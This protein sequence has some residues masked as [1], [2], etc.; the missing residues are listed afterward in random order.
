MYC[1]ISHDYCD[2]LW[3]QNIDSSVCLDRYML[4]GIL[5]ERMNKTTYKRVDDE[6]GMKNGKESVHLINSESM[7]K[8][9][10]RRI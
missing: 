4:G 8:S 7:L 9:I 3:T 2:Q 6:Q 1:L 10:S 5:N